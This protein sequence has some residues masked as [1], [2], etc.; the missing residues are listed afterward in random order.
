MLEKNKHA[1]TRFRREI[2]ALKMFK[3]KKHDNIV[4]FQHFYLKN[5]PM[6]F[7]MDY[8]EGPN[9]QQHIKQ[10][11]N[12]IFGTEREVVSFVLKIAK[13]LAYVHD[14][15]LVHRDVKPAN[16]FLDEKNNLNPVLGDFGLVSYMEQE[17]V[18]PS[19]TQ[20]IVGSVEFLAP[21]QIKLKKITPQAD[22]YSLALVM[23]YMLTGVNPYVSGTGKMAIKLDKIDAKIK[24]VSDYKKG[25]LNAKLN[26]TPTPVHKLN[27]LISEELSKMISICLNIDPEERLESM[28]SMVHYLE[29]FLQDKTINIVL[30]EKNKNFFYKAKKF[31]KEIH[32]AIWFF[33]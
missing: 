20:G 32:S 12:Y 19:I 31:F 8:I 18:L 14:F 6:L 11:D 13:A 4:G 16:I 24:D 29:L 26:L 22:I 1:K 21:E 25:V 9:L 3:N 33:F 17:Y 28:T 7:I 10:K 15:K 27:P 5:D 23:Y 30:I 2:H